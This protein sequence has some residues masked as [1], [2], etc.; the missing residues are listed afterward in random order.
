MIDDVI[1]ILLNANAT[2]TGLVEHDIFP[3]IA[4]ESNTEKYIT[5][6][7]ISDTPEHTKDGASTLDVIRVQL[8]MYAP[9]KAD[10]DAIAVA[11]RNVLD[12]YR[13]TVGAY[14]VDK[15]WFENDTNDFDVDSGRYVVMNDYMIRHKK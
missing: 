3:N 15:I 6:H 8:S 14:T 12:H 11:V 5:V 1:Y 13:G 9:N 4:D 2:V 7:R 10:V